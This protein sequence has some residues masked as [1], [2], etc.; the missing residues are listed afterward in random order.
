LKISREVKTAVLVVSGILLFIYIFNYLKGEDIFNSSRTFYTI[1]ENVEGLEPSSPVTISGNI[2]GKVR[3][4]KFKDDG[5]GKLLVSLL[6]DN[7]FEFSK[8]SKAELYEAGL[9]G[10]KAVAI[11]PAFDDAEIARKGDFLEGTVK[12]YSLT[13]K[14]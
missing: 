6:L 10:G 9:I 4:I 8:N 5:S 11:I 1:Y 14:D 12:A 13:R 2:V 7:N 3:D